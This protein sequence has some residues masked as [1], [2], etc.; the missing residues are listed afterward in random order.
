[1]PQRAGPDLHARL[2]AAQDDVDRELMLRLFSGCPLETVPAGRQLLMQND[3][4]GRIFGLVDGVIESSIV[5]SQGH[6]LVVD[7]AHAPS[8]VGE[9]SGLDGGTAI[10]TVICRSTCELVSLSR[11]QLLN[12]LDNDPE[13]SRD[14]ILLLCRRIRWVSDQ[15]SDRTFLGIETRLAKRLLAL[16]VAFTDADGWL[17]T[18]QADLAQALGATR[19]SVN[20]I[21]NE[22]QSEKAI[23]IRRG[24]IRILD[25]THLRRGH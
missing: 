15:L 3:T 4:V 22:W 18:S 13:L 9:L 14:V 8:V 5:S 20:K 12:R 19:E 21:L 24:R 16:A 2:Y 1:M 17:V 7:L 6:K 25:Q 23:T 10:A 11:A